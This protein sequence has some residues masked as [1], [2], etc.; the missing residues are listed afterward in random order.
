[1]TSTHLRQILASNSSNH[2]LPNGHA[3][4]NDQDDD[5]AD[6]KQYTEYEEDEKPGMRRREKEDISDAD[7]EVQEALLMED[8]LTVLIVGLYT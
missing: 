5:E 4:D 2:D 7:L 6:L 1:V 3:N 8:L